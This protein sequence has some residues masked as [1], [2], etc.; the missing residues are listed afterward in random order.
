MWS[1]DLVAPRLVGSSPAWEV[2]VPCIARQVLNHCTTRE[3]R[4]LDIFLSLLSCPSFSLSSCYQIRIILFLNSVQM[5]LM[6]SK[7]IKNRFHLTRAPSAVYSWLFFFFSQ[8]TL[9]RPVDHV[10]HNPIRR[11]KFKYLIDH[12]VSLTG[13]G[14]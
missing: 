11:N 7:T 4:S 10:W 1:L 3:T 8:G 12:P 13:A 6:Y 5:P 14:R 9:P 2:L